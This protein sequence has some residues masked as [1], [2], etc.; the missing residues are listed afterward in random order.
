MAYEWSS[1]KNIANIKKHGISFETATY[2]FDDPYC[3]EIYDFQHSIDEERYISIGKVGDI[4][5]VVYTYR[6]ENIRI[7][8]ARPATKLERRLYYEQNYNL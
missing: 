2:V 3:V 8:S 6:G 4:I 5:F 7:I 1:D